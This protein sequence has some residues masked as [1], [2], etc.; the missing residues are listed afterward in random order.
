MG[1]SQNEKY[2]TCLGEELEFLSFSFCFIL[3]ALENCDQNLS[4]DV[5]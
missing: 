3:K 4:R 1:S 5:Q 2:L